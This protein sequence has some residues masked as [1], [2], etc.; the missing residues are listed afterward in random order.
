MASSV[1]DHQFM[2]NAATIAAAHGVTLATAHV[3]ASEVSL[4]G[5][6]ASSDFLEP[7]HFG[8]PRTAATTKIRVIQVST[9]FIMPASDGGLKETLAARSLPGQGP[10]GSSGLSLWRRAW[11]H[12]VGF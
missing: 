5:L 6:R 11:W 7:F 9:Q 4:D 12:T 2:M 3:Q 8:A 1:P 10:G